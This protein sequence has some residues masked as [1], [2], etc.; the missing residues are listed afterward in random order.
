[1]RK[2]NP[3]YLVVFIWHFRKVIE[4][5]IDFIENGGTLIFVLPRIHYVNKSNYKIT[6]IVPLKISFKI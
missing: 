5:E 3:D 6:Q 2:L 4:D 1:M